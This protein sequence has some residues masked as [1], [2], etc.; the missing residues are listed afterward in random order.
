MNSSA[1]TTKQHRLRWLCIAIVILLAIF[2]NYKCLQCFFFSD[3]FYCIDYLF[4][5]FHGHPEILW[6]RLVSSW[7]PRST[8]LFYRPVCDLTFFLDYAVWGSNPLGYHIFNL[9][10]YI[11]T[12]LFTFKF[13]ERLAL[14]RLGAGLA[15]L[16]AFLSTAVFATYPLH[17]EPVVWPV[18][19]ADLIAASF[20]LWSMILSIN[21][22]AS[23]KQ[24]ASIPALLL[25]AIALLSKESIACLPALLFVYRICLEENRP[26]IR[27]IVKSLMPHLLLTAA[28]LLL[29]FLVL[30]TIFGGYSASFGEAIKGRLWQNT[31]EWNSLSIL[32]LGFNLLLFDPNQ[33]EVR[34]LHTVYLALGSLMAL[35][36]FRLPWQAP[37]FRLLIF[38]AVA[39]FLTY[40]PALQ[41]IN[42]N[43]VLSNS[44]IFFLP[45]VFFSPF[46]VLMFLPAAQN[47]VSERLLLS[48]RWI[49]GLSIGSLA[50]VFAFISLKNYAPWVEASDLLVTMKDQVHDALLKVPDDKRLVVLT[51]TSNLD[52]AHVMYAS[53]DLETIESK[54]FFPDDQSPKLLALDEFPE[55]FQPSTGR[56][57]FCLEHP[58]KYDVRMFELDSK[59]LLPLSLT[60]W[61]Q[62]LQTITPARIRPAE[63]PPT[64]GDSAVWVEL[65]EP[66]TVDDGEQ[67]ELNVDWRQQKAIRRS[68]FCL[69][70]TGKRPAERYLHV[71]AWPRK[72]LSQHRF[73]TIDLR[74]MVGSKTVNELYVQLPEGAQLTSANLVPARYCAELFPDLSTVKEMP[75][76]NYEILADGFSLDLDVSK[77]PGAKNMVLEIAEPDYLFDMGKDSL[78]SPRTYKFLSKTIHLNGTKAKFDAKKSDFKRGYRYAFRL[79][80]TGENGEYTGSYSDTVC[81]DLR[82]LP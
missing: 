19:R 34:A 18:G 11:V 42:V 48:L 70:D 24:L 49:T 45:S 31:F 77:V 56:L 16:L 25:Y 51:L 5:G 41:V 63:A 35:R 20:M 7:M 44:R 23:K 55:F 72:G 4:K 36:V 26:S 28:Y 46:L 30:G 8:A 60:D 81:I 69:S 50:V 65:P 37:V 80:A 67:V 21:S 12:C 61:S 66:S 32:A 10:A 79:C 58:E 38:F 68:C 15:L 33:W 14:E 59:M 29:R 71:S 82:Y 43:G 13:I 62:R 39:G 76:G 74:R 53:S 73:F 22:I 1:L 27:E 52:G 3:D 78:R 9:L 75:R 40:I 17:V 47:D 2:A 54:A 57:H 64:Q 6:E